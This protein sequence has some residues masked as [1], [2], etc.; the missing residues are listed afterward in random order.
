VRPKC[1]SEKVNIARRLRAE[2]TLTLKKVAARLHMGKW[3]TAS[4][5]LYKAK[6]AILR[7]DPR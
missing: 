3:T 2:T 1:A 5:L 7:T 4:S 6:P